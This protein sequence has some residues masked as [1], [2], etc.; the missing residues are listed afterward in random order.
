MS[1]AHS[2]PIIVPHQF[3]LSF[4][5]G[6]ALPMVASRVGKVFITICSNP[7]QSALNFVALCNH[8]QAVDDDLGAWLIVNG[9]TV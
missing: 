6:R 1:I 2:F 5:V 3:S 4:D 7:M 8:L 9:G